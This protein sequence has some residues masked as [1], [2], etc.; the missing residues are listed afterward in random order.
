MFGDNERMKVAVIGSRGLDVDEKTIEGLLPCYTT[1]I[2]SG[3]A[4]GI[5]ACAKAYARARGIPIREF[6]PDYDRY[7]RA[8]PIKRNE[9][10]VDY[11]DYV[12]AIWDCKS[13]G[14]KNVI[15]LCRK[16]SKPVT[17]YEIVAKMSI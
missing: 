9:Q 11:A 17:V 2:V 16:I 5:D 6:W 12:V 7:G 13:K 4:K 3:G 15:D 8:A 14:T 1:E 10:I